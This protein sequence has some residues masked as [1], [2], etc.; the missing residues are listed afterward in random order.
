M[1]VKLNGKEWYKVT[2]DFGNQDSAHSTDYH[3]GMDLSMESGT[4]IYSPIDGVVK[5]IVDYGDKSLGRGIFI[6]TEDGNTMILGHLSD[7]KVEIGQKISEGDLI[8][9]SGNTGNSTGAHLHIGFKDEN[10]YFIDPDIYLTSTE[11]LQ[12]KMLGDYLIKDEEVVISPDGS[13]IL[14]SETLKTA[15]DMNTWEFIQSWK[16]EGFFQT[17][18]GKSFFEVVKDFFAEL[19]T[20]IGVFILGNGD[21]FF[22]APAIVFMFGTFLVG[23]NKFTK[24]IIP[25]WFAYFISTF[26][27]KVLL[28]Q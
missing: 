23:S 28:A 13:S 21:I 3:T 2:S 5:D 19:F 8:A 10:G 25:L 24:F 1:K 7:E 18:Y 4:E 6:E 9:L 22:L 20:D 27:H 14:D 12:P 17:M 16:E 11:D 26:F 15:K